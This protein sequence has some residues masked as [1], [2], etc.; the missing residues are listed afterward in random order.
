M[1][2]NSNGPKPGKVV[3]WARWLLVLPFIATLF[4]SSYNR[5]EP[6]LAGFPFF[7]W[8]QLLWVI[9]GAII[10]AVVYIVER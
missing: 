5:A 9:I 2:A 7:Y 10:V 8:Y 4:V 3:P 6:Y 1:S